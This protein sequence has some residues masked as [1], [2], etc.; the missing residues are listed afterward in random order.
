[1]RGSLSVDVLAGTL[2]ALSLVV[3]VYVVFVFAPNCLGG[4]PGVFGSVVR[5]CADPGPPPDRLS[6]PPLRLSSR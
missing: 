3:G 2:P 5:F 1:M 4:K 6:A